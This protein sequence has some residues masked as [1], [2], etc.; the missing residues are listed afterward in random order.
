MVY[1]SAWNTVVPLLEPHLS[2][3]WTCPAIHTC[4]ETWL[5]KAC[6]THISVNILSDPICKMG[7]CSISQ[8]FSGVIKVSAF[9]SSLLGTQQSVDP[10]LGPHA[11]VIYI[12]PVTARQFDFCNL[13]SS[14]CWHCIWPPGTKTWSWS[15]QVWSIWY[16]SSAPLWVSDPRFHQM[17][18]TGPKSPVGLIHH[19]LQ[20]CLPSQLLV[21]NKFKIFDLGSQ[22]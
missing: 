10:C 13:L 15:I 16:R 5:W 20:L 7:S 11:G 4:Q 9:R 3:I 8:R 22:L 2:G 12:T 6:G 21:Q 17:C 14:S 19:I 1:I 18:P